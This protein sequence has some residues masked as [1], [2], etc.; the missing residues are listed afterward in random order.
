M[1]EPQP[2][3]SIM[4]E[5]DELPGVIAFRSGVLIRRIQEL[6]R[7]LLDMNLLHEQQIDKLK[8][9]YEVELANLNARIMTLTLTPSPANSNVTYLSGTDTSSISVFS[10]LNDVTGSLSGYIYPLP[11]DVTYK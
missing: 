8:R 5:E 9:E 10:K 4:M 11:D 6:E 7:Q 3:D 1:I 2:D